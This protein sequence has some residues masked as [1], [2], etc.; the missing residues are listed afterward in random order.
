MSIDT[1]KEQSYKPGN[2][3]EP[4]QLNGY[5]TKQL[6]STAKRGFN[7]EEVKLLKARNQWN[8]DPIRKGEP[9][10]QNKKNRGG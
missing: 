2:L 8:A 10:Y 6:V 1:T 4:Y 3:N 9:S 7:P 5:Y